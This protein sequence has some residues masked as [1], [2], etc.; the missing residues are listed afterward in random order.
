MI[1]LRTT[2]SISF[3]LN[4]PNLIFV[5]MLTIEYIEIELN[6]TFIKLAIFEHGDKVDPLRVYNRIFYELFYDDVVKS[7]EVFT[8]LHHNDYTIK[9]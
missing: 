2:N 5:L 7:I 8:Y 1:T 9:I 6:S 4:T 3:S